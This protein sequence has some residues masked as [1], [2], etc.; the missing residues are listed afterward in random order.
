[1]SAAVIRT[2][3]PKKGDLV[4]GHKVY[5]I[6]PGNLPAIRAKVI[7]TSPTGHTL[8]IDVGE[9]FSILGIPRRTEWTWR[10]SVHAYQQK[11]SR[12]SPGWGLALIRRQP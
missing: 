7:A 5:A 1:M 3:R 8:T 11:G 9:L 4:V 2:Q 10:K 12:T 6:L